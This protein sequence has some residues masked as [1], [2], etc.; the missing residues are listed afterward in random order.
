[1]AIFG[2]D[3]SL[4]IPWYAPADLRQSQQCSLATTGWRRVTQW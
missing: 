1:L 2:T 4:Y 3:K